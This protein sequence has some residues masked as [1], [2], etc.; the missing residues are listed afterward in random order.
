MRNDQ[1]EIVHKRENMIG[2]IVIAVVALPIN[3]KYLWQTKV[4]I[5]EL[6]EER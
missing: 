2:W 6:I 5:I 3:G 4:R 1:I